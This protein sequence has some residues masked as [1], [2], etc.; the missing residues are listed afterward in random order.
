MESGRWR[1][2]RR[3]RK[4]RDVGESQEGPELAE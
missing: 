1:E 3:K 2:E 4:E